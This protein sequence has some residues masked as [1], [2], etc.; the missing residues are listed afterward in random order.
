VASGNI[1]A[2]PYGPVYDFCIERG[3]LMRPLARVVWGADL[4]PLY[5][6]MAVIGMAGAGE[7]ILDVPCGGGVA[8]RAL[9]PGQDV[10]YIAGDISQQMLARAKQRAGERRLSQ[11][12]FAL[13]DMENLPFADGIADL[14]LS[15]SGLHMLEDPESAVREIGRCLKPGGKFVGCTFV[16]EG[17]LRQRALFRAGEHLGHPA[18][19]RAEN[20]HRWLGDAGIT[21]TVIEPARG[22]VLFQGTKPAN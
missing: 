4:A 5:S 15:Y 16:R 18:P 9:S 10:R 8:F 22:F 12:E 2:G 13:A 3:R 7:T 11:V 6:T 20:L 21:D 14:F 17:A 19:P 1:C